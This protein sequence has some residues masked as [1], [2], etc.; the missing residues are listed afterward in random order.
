[1][2]KE[3][4]K[5]FPG[6]QALHN[7][8]TLAERIELVRQYATDNTEYNDILEILPQAQEV[9]G[10]ELSNESPTPRKTV[11]CIWGC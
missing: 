8:G 4:N 10:G 5:S 7:L 3:A 11:T 2:E 6:H 1:M 9:E